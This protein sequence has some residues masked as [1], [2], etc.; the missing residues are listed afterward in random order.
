MKET[1]DNDMHKVKCNEYTIWKAG[2]TSLSTYNI[3][4]IIQLKE[5][6]I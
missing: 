3:G 1:L 4:I 5:R 2:I 6:C